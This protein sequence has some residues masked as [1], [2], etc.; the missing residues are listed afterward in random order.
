MRLNVAVKV[1]VL[2]A[3]FAIGTLTCTAGAADWP[4]WRGPD[5]NGISKETGFNPAALS[6]DTKPLW[7]AVSGAI[8]TILDRITLQEL[9]DGRVRD[10]DMKSLL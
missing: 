5:Y 9:I 8:E 7:E 1:S 3:L 2:L 6:E 4:H 10:M